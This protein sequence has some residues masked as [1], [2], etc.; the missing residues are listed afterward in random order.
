MISSMECHSELAPLMESSSSSSSAG[1]ILFDHPNVNVAAAND[2]VSDDTTSTRRLPFPLP[3][4]RN[5]FGF[6]D[7]HDVFPRAASASAS[8]CSS[9]PPTSDSDNPNLFS[10]S[11]PQPS[12]HQVTIQW[13]KISAAIP[14]TAGGFS[15]YW[16]GATATQ[17]TTKFSGGGKSPAGPQRKLFRGVRQR[18]WGKWVAEIRLPRNRTRVWLGTFDTAREAALAYDTA[19]YILRGDYAHLNFPHLKHQ[20][21]AGNS[22]M[23]RST[24]AL[25]QAKLQGTAEKRAAA[26][27]AAESAESGGGNGNSETEKKI[28]SSLSGEETGGDEAV[29]LSR[30][31]SLD[32][33]VIWDA[34]LR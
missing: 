29:Q 6:N 23:A 30:M 33:D 27:A 5:H 18:H 31:P 25:L 19:A 4:P 34:L 3:T 15:D 20:I 32:M 14:S 26:S 24:A 11:E 12:D 17:P 13:L 7:D 1:S 10:L 8:H 9:F 28:C 21:N 16:L 22:T 2:V